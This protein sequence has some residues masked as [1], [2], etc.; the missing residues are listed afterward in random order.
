MAAYGV[1]LRDHWRFDRAGVR[2]LTTRRLAELVNGLSEGSALSRELGDG[3]T[4]TDYLIS[5]VM[6]V[7]TGDPHPSDP[8]VAARHRVDTVRVE[9][10]AERSRARRERLGIRGSVLGGKGQESA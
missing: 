7:L 10:A 9:S 4:T 2:L 5:D 3:W 1:D 6:S 8:R